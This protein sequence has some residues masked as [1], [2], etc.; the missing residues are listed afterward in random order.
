MNI[1]YVTDQ[2]GEETVIFKMNMYM[3]QE[4]IARLF[5]L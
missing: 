5:D 2:R 4:T 3:G 1:K